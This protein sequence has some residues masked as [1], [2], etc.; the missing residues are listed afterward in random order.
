MLVLTRKVGESIVINDNIIVKVSH[1]AGSR[2][3]IAIEAPRSTPILR[4]EVA[5]SIAKANES[6]EP[7]PNES[8]MDSGSFSL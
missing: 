1:L 5:D 4:S 2:V 8:W 7:S 6:N 3:K